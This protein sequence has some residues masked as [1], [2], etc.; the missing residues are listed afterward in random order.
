MTLPF[1]LYSRQA[2][3]A[4]ISINLYVQMHWVDKDRAV[5]SN[6][7]TRQV[8]RRSYFNASLFSFIGVWSDRGGANTSIFSFQQDMKL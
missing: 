8:K 5:E 1:Q 3:R 6:G 7:L 2:I 4:T